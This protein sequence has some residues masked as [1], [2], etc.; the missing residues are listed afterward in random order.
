MAILFFDML[1]NKIDMTKAEAAVRRAEKQDNRRFRQALTFSDRQVT[2]S[3]KVELEDAVS[4]RYG[5][6]IIVGELAENVG[7]AY[8]VKN[9]LELLEKDPSVQP[10]AGFLGIT[11]TVIITAIVALTVILVV[12]MLKNYSIDTDIEVS[13]ANPKIRLKLNK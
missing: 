2:V 13:D 5:T 6:I 11:E 12:A 4:K 3:T 10:Q 7:R 1:R 9:K 8:K